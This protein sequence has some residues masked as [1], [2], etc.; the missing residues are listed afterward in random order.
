VKIEN[1]YQG[2]P[3]LMTNRR[4]D[5]IILGSIK[6]FNLDI[7]IKKIIQKKPWINPGLFND[8]LLVLECD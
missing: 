8:L 4:R 5:S 6:T 2:V 7:C 3:K 1:P